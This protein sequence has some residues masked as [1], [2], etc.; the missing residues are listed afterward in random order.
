MIT[1]DRLSNLAKLSPRMGK[2]LQDENQL[3]NMIISSTAI[4]VKST[5]VSVTEAC[6]YKGNVLS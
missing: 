3:S 4:R 2:L 1:R 5:A 6:D